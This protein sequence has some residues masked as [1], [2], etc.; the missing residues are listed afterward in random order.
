MLAEYLDQ[1]LDTFKD[2]I[3]IT[4]RAGVIIYLNRRHSELTGIPKEDLLGKSAIEMMR[5]GVFDVVL[6]PEIVKTRQGTTSIQNISNGRKLFLDG[7]PILDREGEVVYVVTFMRDVTTLVELKRELASQK[8]LLD[9]FQSLSSASPERT[10]NYPQMMHSAVM[11]NICEQLEGIAETDATVLLLGD[12]GVGKDVLARRLHSV[13]PRA[14]KP[15]IKAD[16]ASIP[17]N[18]IETELFGYT[19]G[20]FSGGNRHGKM[21]LIEAAAGGTLFLDEIGELPMPMQSRLLRLLQDREVMRVG[22]T[23]SSRVDV[24]IVAATNKDL[25]KE[26]RDGRFRSDLY[27]RLKVAVVRIPPL[28]QRKADIVPLA[29]GFLKF[30]CSKYRRSLAL[31][32]QAEDALREHG[33]PGNVRELENLMQGLVVTC[34][35]NVIEPRDLPFVR[36]AQAKAAPCASAGAGVDIEGRSFKDIMHELEGRVLRQ[37]LARYG[38]I[39]EVA[40]QFGVD[41]STIFRKLKGGQED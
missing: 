14:G 31:S 25:E 1:L 40:K 2:A 7:S 9:A 39:A 24:R 11:R 4:D 19:P 22:S 35:R 12:T 34:Q 27:Y 18:L 20:T 13:S 16:C 28:R 32:P 37:A 5:H 29:Q 33:W 41:R 38:T 23:T 3:C 30:Y 8:E 15:F 26:V 6:N 21:G 17:A 36:P 10:E